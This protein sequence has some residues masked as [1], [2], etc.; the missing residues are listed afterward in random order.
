[1]VR[2]FIRTRRRIFPYRQPTPTR[3]QAYRTIPSQTSGHSFH[4]ASP[5]SRREATASLPTRLATWG[6]AWRRRLFVYALSFSL[7]QE[8]R[9]GRAKPLFLALVPPAALTSTPTPLHLFILSRSAHHTFPARWPL[10]CSI[11]RIPISL[12]S[13]CSSLLLLLTWTKLANVGESATGCTDSHLPPFIDVFFT[14]LARPFRQS[15]TLNCVT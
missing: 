13:F 1:M 11:F 10:D 2:S 8:H 4:I 7:N 5:F 3:P 12:L 6:V 14:S 9:L 15:N